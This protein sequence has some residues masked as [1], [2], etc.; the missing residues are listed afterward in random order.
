[1]KVPLQVCSQTTEISFQFIEQSLLILKA[2]TISDQRNFT[3]HIFLADISPA[4]VT[5]GVHNTENFNVSRE[6]IPDQ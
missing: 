1:M 2:E 6:T 3:G 4:V 5:R